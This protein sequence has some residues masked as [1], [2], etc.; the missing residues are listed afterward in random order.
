MILAGGSRLTACSALFLALGGLAAR[1][2]AAEAPTRVC[3]IAGSGRSAAETGE[4]V[5]GLADFLGREG[6]A[7]CTVEVLPDGGGVG[8]LSGA[9][10]TSDAAVVWVSGRRLTEEGKAAVRGFIGAGRGLVVVGAGGGV[11]TDWPEFEPEVLGS[12]F[13]GRFAGGAPMRV[14]N[15]FPHPIFAGVDHFD[16]QEPM[17][18]C[19]LVPGVQVV[20]EGIV[21]EEAVPMAWVRRVGRARVVGLEPGGRALLVDPDFRAIVANSVLWAAA[22]PVPRA[23]TIVQRTYMG[24]SYPGALAISFPEGPSLCFDTVRG[25]INYIWDG[26]FVDLHPWW[27][28]RHGSPLRTFAARYSGGVLYRANTLVP[29]M[30]VGQKSGQSAFR[31]R[32]YRM[33]GDGHPELLYSVGG[34]EVS[35]DLY[36]AGDGIGVECAYHVAPGPSPLWLRLDGDSA[37]DIAVSGA[38]RD[39]NLAR[40]DGAAGG[41]FTVR[42]RKGGGFAQ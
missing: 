8:E 20:M 38:A 4:A 7:L 34:R 19:A 42:I 6:N 30:H 24:D 3:L 41:D 26:D 40:F 14:I 32:G 10:G 25:A 13:G 35:E 2:A 36:A 22:R 31:F 39:G 33:M 12:R 9:L 29:A 17:R 11:W 5:S 28:G 23:R 16:T 21:G 27:T 1:M 15:L 37:A 18:L